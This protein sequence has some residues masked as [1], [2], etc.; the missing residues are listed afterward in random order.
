MTT[1]PPKCSF[2]PGGFL[3][4]E[5]VPEEAIAMHTLNYLRQAHRQS[6]DATMLEK[7]VF[8]YMGMQYRGPN[9]NFMLAKIGGCIEQ[10]VEKGD[11][12]YVETKTKVMV[13][14]NKSATSS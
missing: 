1:K 8:D 11:V 5:Q 6:C 10:L 2:T 3:D 7:K 13:K 9:R 14:L 12:V 4:V